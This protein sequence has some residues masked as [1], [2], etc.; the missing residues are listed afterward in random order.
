MQAYL[1]RLQMVEIPAFVTSKGDA[2]AGSVLVKINTLDGNA[3]V[4]QR[5]YD[6]NGARIW[7]VLAEGDEAIVDAS[8]TK[9]RGF[10]PDIWVIEVED[11]AGRHLLGEAGFSD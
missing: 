11:K 4:F 10:D 9:Q 8:L 5:S 3:Q 7:A 1:R 2:H 6:L